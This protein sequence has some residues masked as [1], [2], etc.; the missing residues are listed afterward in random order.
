LSNYSDLEIM[1]KVQSG[2]MH[3]MGILYE[4]HKTNLY[5]YFYRCTSNREKSEDLVQ[6]VFLKVLRSTHLFKGTSGEFKYWLFRIARNTWIDSAKSK[7]PTQKAMAFENVHMKGSFDINDDK[8]YEKQNRIEQLR[9]ALNQIGEEKREAI[10]MSRYQGLDYKTIAKISNC[11][12]SAV[13]S[14]IMRGL[15]D[16]RA[17]V[18]K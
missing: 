13:K 17:I 3:L 1:R 15:N 6:N 4:R 8:V 5:S 2:E 16:I 18:K 12:E 10:I 11:T 7:E 14:R 9:S